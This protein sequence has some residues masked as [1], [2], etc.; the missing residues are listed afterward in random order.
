MIVMVLEPQISLNLGEW[1][2][3]LWI[4]RSTFLNYFFE[5]FN[6]LNDQKI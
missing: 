3:L 5:V 1:N 6:D 4:Y 2:L